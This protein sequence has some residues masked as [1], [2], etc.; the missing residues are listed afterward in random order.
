MDLCCTCSWFF[1]IKVGRWLIIYLSRLCTDYSPINRYLVLQFTRKSKWEHESGFC[2]VSGWAS[3]WCEKVLS[4]DQRPTTI[5]D[6]ALW[7]G[8][9]LDLAFCRWCVWQRRWL[10]SIAYVSTTWRRYVSGRAVVATDNCLSTVGP[11]RSRQSRLLRQ[12]GY[13]K[14]PEVAVFCRHSS[15][16]MSTVENSW[17]SWHCRRQGV[18]NSSS[19]K[20][21]NH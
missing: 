13:S 9:P 5:T 7:R 19:F 10:M 12:K 20:R 17:L 18:D 8:H 4:L 11:S 3:M 21:C 2:Q 14:P 15:D 16:G 6:I 1:D